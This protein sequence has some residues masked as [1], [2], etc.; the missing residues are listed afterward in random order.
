MGSRSSAGAGIGVDCS[1]TV[2]GGRIADGR[3][4]AQ[5]RVVAPVEYYSRIVVAVLGANARLQGM[6]VMNDAALR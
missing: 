2:T 6:A 1:R 5:D 3:L 4:P